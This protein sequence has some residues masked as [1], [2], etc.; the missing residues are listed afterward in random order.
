M[1]TP[2]IGSRIKAGKNGGEQLS[3]LAVMSL[4]MNILLITAASMAAFRYFHWLSLNSRQK[5]N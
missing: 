1:N 4:F 3:K 5:L 2:I